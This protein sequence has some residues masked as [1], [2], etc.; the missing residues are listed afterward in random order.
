VN[1]V[2]DAV[3]FGELMLRLSPPGKQRISHGDLLEKN[4]GGAELNVAAG[5]SALGLK[6][7][8]ISKLPKNDI[9][10][11]VTEKVKACGV[12]SSYIIADDKK[13]ARLGVYYYESGATPRTPKV[14]YDRAGS[15]VNSITINEIN[16]DIY[17]C[18]K[19]FH[20]SG[21]T[22]ALG[23]NVRETAIEMMK[24]FK[25]GGAKISFDVNY[26]ASLW[27]EDEARN[28][29]KQILPLVDVLFV[30]EETSRR[31]FQKTGELRDILKS[32]CEEYGI[33]VVAATKREI[34][35]PSSH[36]FGSTIYESETDTFYSEKPYEGIEVVDRIGSGDAYVAGML[37]GL[38]KFGDVQKSLE[39]GNA[40]SAVQ[41]TVN[42]DLPITSYSEIENVIAAHKST[43]LQS[44]MNR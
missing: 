10:A 22:L 26:R 19:L 31:M 23:G 17:S 16:S 20:T 35:S 33:S 37:F 40:M 8:V 15:S 4:A 3:S 39:F 6:T 9:V 38:L 34:I 32:Y 12:D 5:I 29:I 7:A 36:N 18:T 28:T 13:E 42:G 27:S 25:V 11:F 43:G 24:L 1:K 44:E 41:N 21:I 30:S 2:Y 14:L